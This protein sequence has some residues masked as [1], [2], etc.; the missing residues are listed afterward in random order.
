MF[1]FTVPCTAQDLGMERVDIIKKSVVKVFINN[2]SSGTGFIVNQ[3]CNIITCWH[4]IQQAIT[5]DT[6]KQLKI[7]KKI[8]IELWNKEKYEVGIFSR[9]FHDRQKNAVAYD[10]CVLIPIN[11]PKTEFKFLKVG[12]FNNISEGDKILT[13]GYPLGI[14]QQFISTGIL[15]TKWQDTV[16]V[17]YNSKIDTLIKNVAWLDLTMNKG[18]SGGPILKIGNTLLEDEVIGIA[19]FIL[20]PYAQAAESLANA[21]SN[22]KADIVSGG[23]SQAQ[24]NLLY[25]KAISLNSIGISGC[26]SINHLL[27]DL[28]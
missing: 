22:P 3:D 24:T 16:I 10:Y 19:T 20:S 11:K 26:I 2:T 27:N 1:V 4:V 12:N 8:E 9:L 14:N 21:Y 25:A 13:C 6:T 7:N 23:L 5:I 15:S 28:Q 18:N 17:E